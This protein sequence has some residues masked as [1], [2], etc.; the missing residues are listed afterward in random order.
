MKKKQFESLCGEILSNLPGFSCKGWLLHAVPLDHILRGFCCDGSS[1][2]PSIFTVTVFVL[3]LY[4]PTTHL[5]FNMGKRLKDERGCDKWWN[6]GEAD[7]SSKLL[8]SVQ[9]DGLPFLC[10][11]RSP[12]EIIA[13]VQRLP[14]SSNPH[15]LEAI[16]YSLAMAGEYFAAQLA[17]ERLVK[18][19]DVKISWQLEMAE[20]AKLLAEKLNADPEAGKLLLA[21]W[22]LETIN[23]LAL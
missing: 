13:V 20:R 15:S 9:H 23:A 17:L 21:T 6:I 8:S 2:D 18:A 19:L 22:E 5:H 1:F 10:G 3:P 14:G 11:V 16:A 7:L 4:V 12:S